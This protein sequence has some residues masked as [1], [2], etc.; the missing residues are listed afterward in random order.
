SRADVEHSCGCRAFAGA[1]AASVC[2]LGTER[3][4][5]QKISS[6]NAASTSDSESQVAVKALM[7]RFTYGKAKKSTMMTTSGGSAR[8]MSAK[9]TIRKLAGLK[10]SERAMAS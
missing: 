8:N 9:T 2:P 1:Q 4:P 6:A 10:C 3:M 7:A 5:A